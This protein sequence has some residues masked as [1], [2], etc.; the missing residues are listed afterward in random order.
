MLRF[1]A[2]L[3]QRPES[4]A[5]ALDLTK[6]AFRSSFGDSRGLGPHSST[7]RRTIILG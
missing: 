6:S 3:P 2:F 4:E 1:A 7:P 5:E